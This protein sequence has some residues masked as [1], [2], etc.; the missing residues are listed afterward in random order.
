MLTAVLWSEKWLGTS[1]AQAPRRWRTAS[2]SEWMEV[3]GCWL[4]L[5]DLFLE[6]MQGETGVWQTN[7]LKIL[8]A[9]MSVPS[10]EN[11][12][13]WDKERLIQEGGSFY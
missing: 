1:A 12:H 10:E 8:D 13:L 3:G 9:P 4:A 7:H 5:I 2:G 6:H 11:K